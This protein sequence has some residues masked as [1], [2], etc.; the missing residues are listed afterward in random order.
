MPAD[1][2]LTLTLMFKESVIELK[3]GIWNYYKINEVAESTHFYFFPKHKDKSVTLTYHSD[4][5]DLKISYAL[6][7]F[8]Y[9]AISPDEWPFPKKVTEHKAL[10]YS[11]T[12]LVHV[13]KES[14]EKCWPTCVLLV[15]TFKDDVS[16]KGKFNSYLEESKFK[17][18]VSNSYLELPQRTKVDVVM[19]KAE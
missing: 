16:L 12:K 3:D 5:V 7:R 10:K 2:D 11:P 9:K 17:I 1:I 6:W 4:S 14:L 8:D 18:M 15:S 13:S 19:Q